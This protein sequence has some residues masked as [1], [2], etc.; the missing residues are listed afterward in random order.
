MSHKNGKYFEFPGKKVKKIITI[1]E[2]TSTHET[3][4]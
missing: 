4:V 2:Q 3:N 1:V